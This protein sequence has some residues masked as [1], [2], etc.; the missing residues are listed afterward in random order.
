[1]APLPPQGGRPCASIRPSGVTGLSLDSILDCA[2]YPVGA[3][4]AIGGT[5]GAINS[6]YAMVDSRRG[7][8]ATLRALGFRPGTIVASTLCESMRR[9]VPGALLGAALAWFLFSGL[10]ASPFGY[11]FRLD[12]TPALVLLGVI[13]ALV[14]GF[15]GG[16]LPA[17]RAARV[18]VTTALPAT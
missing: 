2:S 15:V 6:L 4:M 13:W 16:I 12:V 10:S 1:M 8:L 18:P 17:L 14:M 3:I 7:E 9:A 11:S 5:L